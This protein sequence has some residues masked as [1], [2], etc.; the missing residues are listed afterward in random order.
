MLHTVRLNLAH[1]SRNDSLGTVFS[2]GSFHKLIAYLEFDC[3]GLSK[4]CPDEVRVLP[5]T[6]VVGD[7][8]ILVDFRVINIESVTLVLK[9]LNILFGVFK[10]VQIVELEIPPA[11]LVR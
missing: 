1:L 9:A 8:N 4:L 7:F 11:H 3:D 5:E 2:H 6:V 10:L